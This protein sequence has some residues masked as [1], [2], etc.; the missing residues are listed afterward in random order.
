MRTITVV[1]TNKNR[2]LAIETGICGAKVKDITDNL[3]AFDVY[4]STIEKPYQFMTRLEAV[5]IAAHGTIVD[6]YGADIFKRYAIYETI[7]TVK[8]NKGDS[9]TD[10]LIRATDR[11]YKDRIIEHVDTRVEAVNAVNKSE[12]T[13]DFISNNGIKYADVKY[14]YAV[15]FKF[16]FETENF[17]IDGDEDI[18][19]SDWRKETEE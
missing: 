6:S 9:Y 18:L 4:T 2:Y 19:I 17:E 16:D 10:I 15:P 12:T 13:I 1:Q 3:E 11:D 5:K 8:V 14:R 7:R